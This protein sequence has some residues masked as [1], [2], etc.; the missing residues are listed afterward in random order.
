MVLKKRFSAS[1]FW[2]DCRAHDVTVILYIGEL[3]RYLVSA[4]RVRF[5]DMVLCL[6]ADPSIVRFEKISESRTTVLL[7]FVISSCVSP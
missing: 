1:A 4:P 3:C 6:S 2:E 5:Y 7:W